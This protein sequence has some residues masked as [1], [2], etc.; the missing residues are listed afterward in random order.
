VVN[1]LDASAPTSTGRS[2]LAR[3]LKDAG[4]APAPSRG[5][6]SGR[7]DLVKMKGSRTRGKPS[8]E[9]PVTLDREGVREKLVEARP[10]R[11]RLLSKYSRGSLASRDVKRSGGNRRGK[12]CPVCASA[13]KNMEACRCWTHRRGAPVD[14]GD[15]VGPTSNQAGGHTAPIEGPY[16]ARLQ[17]ARHP[18]SASFALSRH[19]RHAQ[20]R[21]DLVTDARGRGWARLVS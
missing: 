15:V 3:R 6:A 16:G 9:I 20:G 8:G 4:R 1:R 2:N 5:R 13:A 11:T 21:L 17:D 14:R 12:L 18:T 10:R 19:E 7:R